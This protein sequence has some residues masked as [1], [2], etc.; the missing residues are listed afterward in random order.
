LD[1]YFADRQSLRLIADC[2]SFLVK[3]AF[4]VAVDVL[5][6]TAIADD[7]NLG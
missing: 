4:T 2:G 3:S 7:V 6:E 1:Q 5:A